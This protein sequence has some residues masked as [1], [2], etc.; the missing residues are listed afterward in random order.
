MTLNFRIILLSLVAGFTY[1][2]SY[3]ATRVLSEF[4]VEPDAHKV[5]TAGIQLAIEKTAASKQ[6]GK[7]IIPSGVYVTGTL[8]LRSNVELHLEKGAI[9]LGSINPF[10]YDGYAADAPNDRKVA[11][12]CSQP[13]FGLIVGDR[14]S[15][16]TISGEGIIDGRGL[17][18]ALAVDSLHHTGVRIDPN[19]NTYRMRPSLRPKLFDLDNCAG[20][21]IIGVELRSASAWGLSMNQC[22]DV[23]IKGIRFINRAYWNNDGIDIADCKNVRIENCDINSADDGIVLKSFDPADGNSDIYIS[24]CTIR[25]SANALKFGTESFGG[26]RNVTIKDIKVY[27]TFRSAVAIE[28]VD[29]AVIDNVLVDGVE[30][31]NTGNPLFIRLGHRRGEQPGR[32][33]NVT[34]KNLRCEVPFG[35][36]DSEYDLRGP[37]INVIHNPFPSSITGI[38]EAKVKNVTLEN[39]E[40]IYPGRGTKGM[41]YIGKYRYN[42]VPEV[43]DAYPEFHMF[44]E[45]PA[46]ALYVRHVDGLTLRNVKAKAAAPD[47]RDA[48]VTDDVTA[49][50]GDLEV[51][52]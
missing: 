39:I 13:L 31:K 50:K 44:G 18:V 8:K 20:I 37:D 3:P 23:L 52:K 45:L 4:G 14:V 9:L 6:G 35:R 7:L 12:K 22:K 25:S 30:A 19:Y 24:G 47:Y 26:F 36:P 40:M 34:I 11:D 27:D 43:K 41:G 15:N 16:V 29:G 32:V 46:W 48:M 42:D 1:L 10:D 38:P 51:V 5:Q 17:E 33:E 2:T 21:N 49:L 28:S